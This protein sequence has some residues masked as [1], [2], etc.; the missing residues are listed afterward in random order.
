M[1]PM[2]ETRPKNSSEVLPATGAAKFAAPDWDELY[3]CI[4]VLAMRRSA[5]LLQSDPDS[6]HDFD[7]GA[8][9]LRT[10]M[11]AAEIARRIKTQEEKDNTPDEETGKLPT[12]TDEDIRRVYRDVLAQVEAIEPE[13]AAGENPQGGEA[14]APGKGAGGG[15]ER[16]LGGAR[17]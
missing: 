13:I 11:G 5:L 4:R 15:G 17:S 16:D 12:F 1:P 6:E 9:A 2:F 10:L 14:R 3:D 8:R 7:R